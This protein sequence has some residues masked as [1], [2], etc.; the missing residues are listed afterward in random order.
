MSPWR[1]AH[2]WW[3]SQ[4]ANS[5]LLQMCREVDCPGLLHSRNCGSRLIKSRSISAHCVQMLKTIIAL[6]LIVSAS[7]KG[8]VKGAIEWLQE[9]GEEVLETAEE[10]L[11]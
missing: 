8:G 2:E 4:G 1:Q 5:A 11:A 10:C 9:H 6:G 3:Q 7:A